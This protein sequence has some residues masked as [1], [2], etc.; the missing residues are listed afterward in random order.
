[1]SKQLNAVSK[2]SKNEL[3]LTPPPFPAKSSFHKLYISSLWICQKF[4]KKFSQAFIRCIGQESVRSKMEIRLEYQNFISKTFLVLHPDIKSMQCKKSARCPLYLQSLLKIMFSDTNFLTLDWYYF[5][6]Y[7]WY[8]LAN[9]CF[10]LVA[11]S[12]LLRF[13]N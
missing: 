7:N 5:A 1:M 11:T 3:T 6:Q 4:F 2:C 9:S 12:K 10:S 13:W 8:Y